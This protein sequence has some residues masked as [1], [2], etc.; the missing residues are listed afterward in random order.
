MTLISWPGH[1]T[2]PHT[3]YH[4]RA[5]R[6]QWPSDSSIRLNHYVALLLRLLKGTM[7]H[8][9]RFDM[10]IAVAVRAMIALLHPIVTVTPTLTVDAVATTG[11][12][13]TMALG[14]MPLHSTVVTE[15]DQRNASLQH[16]ALFCFYLQQ[17]HCL[18]PPVAH[19]DPTI[20]R[21]SILL[22]QPTNNSLSP[23]RHSAGMEF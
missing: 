1:T 7:S 9:P 19:L 15:A 10:M 11:P 17:L 13:T 5:T 8:H 12:I 22:C 18:L 21:P 4:R 14:E 16:Q 23:L 2:T 3:T 20:Y 6:N